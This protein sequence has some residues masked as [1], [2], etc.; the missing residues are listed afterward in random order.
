[1]DIK[2]LPPRRIISAPAAHADV[3]LGCEPDEQWRFIGSKAQ[4][5]WLWY[6]YNT[7]TGGVLAY[8]FGP[9]NDKTCRE[10]LALLTPFCIGMATSD[11]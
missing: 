10:L 11:D 2:K 6:A 5:H 7:K 3:A 8:T 4:Q 1:M 9:R